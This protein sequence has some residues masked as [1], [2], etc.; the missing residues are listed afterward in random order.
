M[1]NP[2]KSVSP[3]SDAPT[4]P[5]RGPRRSRRL[6][7][8]LLL[9]G[10]VIAVGYLLWFWREQTRPG[11]R[12]YRKGIEYLSAKRPA[13]AEREWLQGV[14]QDPGFSGCHEQL[15]DLYTELLRFPDA[16]RQY[17]EAARLS[18]DDGSLWYRLARALRM[19]GKKPEAMKAARRAARLL[20]ND[21]D[22]LGDYGILEA[23]LKERQEA[24]PALRRAHQ[25]RPQD[26][27]F[28]IALVNTEMDALEIEPAERDLIPYLQAHPTDA[29][30]CFLMEIVYDHKPRTPENLKAAIDYGRRAIAGM[31]NDEQAYTVLGQLELYAGDTRRALNVYGAGLR[32]W[33]NSPGIIHGLVECYTRTGDTRR[34]ELAAAD[35]EKVTRLHDRIEHLKHVMGFN[36]HDLSSGLE[37]A[38]LEEERGNT[39]QAGVYF[40]QLVRQA[41]KE[42]RAREALVAFYRRQG[43][44]D[45][46]RNA[47]R[48]DFTP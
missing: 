28:F 15:G 12:H 27:R 44:E 1:R 40:E 34:R 10:G 46:A 8:S 31:P 36:N 32:R 9:C 2:V 29:Q 7:L 26:R 48:P 4:H 47:A 21:A 38:R 17:T 30:A 39:R 25:L 3:S 37:L 5:A 19:V 20:P 23:E 33:P 14:Q 43:R 41:P 22:A 6:F 11:V 42:T 13:S 45:L 24:M 35:F 18:P 16:A